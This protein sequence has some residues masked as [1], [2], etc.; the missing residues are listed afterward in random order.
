MVTGGDGDDRLYGEEPGTTPSTAARGTTPSTAR[1]ASTRSTAATGNDVVDGGAAND[2]VTGDAGD[3][4]VRGGDGDDAD[5]GTG[6]DLIYGGL[7][8]D[9]VS[10]A[11]RPST[12]PLTFDL[13]GAP[14][15]GGTSDV[16]QS[17]TPPSS[18]KD[19][20][21]EDVEKIIGGAGADTFLVRLNLAMTF[22]GGAG[23]DRITVDANVTQPVVL[24]GGPGADIE[25]GGGGNDTLIE[26]TVANGADDLAGGAGVDAVDMTA[27]E[28]ARGRDARR[29]R[30]RR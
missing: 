30:Q 24:D 18:N 13:N 10:Y 3:D 11:A 16:A 9:T 15:H 4:Q 20:V 6:A 27:A 7:G 19:T 1:T 25:V 12:E 5:G 29:D 14:G 22:A 2:A 23:N 26:G 8:F 21:R 28:Q 17:A